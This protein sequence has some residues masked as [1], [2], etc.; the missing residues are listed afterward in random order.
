VELS[1]A[2]G[3]VNKI[4]AWRA[5]LRGDF[6]PRQD[7][8]DLLQKKFPEMCFELLHPAWDLLAHPDMNRRT[9][10]RLLARQPEQWHRTRVLLAALATTELS[11]RPSLPDT[12]QLRQLGF[13]DALLLFW[14]ERKDAIAAKLEQRRAALDQILWLLPV[15]YPLDPLWKHAD[16]YKERHRYMLYAIDRGLDLGDDVNPGTKWGWC[17]REG[18]IFKQQWDLQRHIRKYPKAL[19]TAELRMRYFARIWYWPHGDQLNE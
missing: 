15:L 17:G 11:V 5:R 13:L 4:A 10:Q 16:L 7:L 19:K 18:M 12:L 9:L 1:V 8:L 3:G 6:L 14:C 2:T